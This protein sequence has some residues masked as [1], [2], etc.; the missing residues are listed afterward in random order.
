MG[1]ARLPEQGQGRLEYAE[2]GMYVM[3]I[4]SHDRVFAAVMRAKQLV[5][6]IQ[7][8]ETHENDPTTDEPRDPWNA[9]QE[10]FGGLGG[11]LKDTYRRVAEEG[12][13]SEEEIKDAFGT[14]LGAWDQ[15][16]ESVSTALQDPEVRQKLNAAASSFAA[17]VGTTI[18]ELGTELTDSD[19]WRP[20]S[21]EDGAGEEE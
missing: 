1:H 20:T 3:A 6:T 12:G 8:V 18:S 14:L 17:A 19:R 15:V 7:E 10:E 2:S 5:S 21:P 16:V 13:P 9:F 4:G 11:R